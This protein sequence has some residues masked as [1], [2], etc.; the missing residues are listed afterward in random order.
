[1][2]S[3]ARELDQWITDNGYGVLEDTTGGGHLRYRLR[4]GA[5]YHTSR[6]PSSPSAIPNGKSQVRRML[7]L[8]SE[9]PRAASYRHVKT[10]GYDGRP[11]A[12][13]TDW[14]MPPEVAHWKSRVAECDARLAAL[15]PE[16][17]AKEVRKWSERRA[18]AVEELNRYG[19]LAPPF[20]H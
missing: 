4:N 7:G 12:A 3:L 17:Q 13:G 18:A 19:V 6:T 11:A 2:N 14:A 10:D 9:S 15:N 1:V 5:P 8:Q 16:R 20:S